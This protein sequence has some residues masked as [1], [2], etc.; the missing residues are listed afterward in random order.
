LYLYQEYYYWVPIEH[1]IKL[2][3]EKKL[4]DAENPDPDKK[5]T[6]YVPFIRKMKEQ[7]HEWIK[8]QKSISCPFDVPEKVEDSELSKMLIVKGQNLTRY[9]VSVQ[10]LYINISYIILILIIS[11]IK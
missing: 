4:K 5:Q 8:A 3:E 11:N 2:F 9:H 6:C 10:Y 1:C 7:N